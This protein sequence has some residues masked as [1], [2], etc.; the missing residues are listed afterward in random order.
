[1]NYEQ[2]CLA[3]KAKNPQIDPISR[4]VHTHLETAYKTMPSGLTADQ[5]RVYIEIFVAG[6]QAGT[7]EANMDSTKKYL[8]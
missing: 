4:A 2:F 1:M 3:V 6:Y 8:N 5:Q 7:L